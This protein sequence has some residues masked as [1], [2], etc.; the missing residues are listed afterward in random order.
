MGQRM[1]LEDQII[2]LKMASKQMK[3]QSQKCKKQEKGEQIKVKK[4]RLLF[5]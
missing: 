4:V 2:E 1:T 3:R 5:V